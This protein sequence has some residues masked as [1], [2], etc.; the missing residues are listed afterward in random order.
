[1]Y[2]ACG[3]GGMSCPIRLVE[4]R[5]LLGPRRVRCRVSEMRGAKERWSREME[6][7]SRIGSVGAVRQ[8]HSFLPVPFREQTLVSSD[9]CDAGTRRQG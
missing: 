4:T 9:P 5:P 3:V 7:G 8:H 6:V 2:D 1:M